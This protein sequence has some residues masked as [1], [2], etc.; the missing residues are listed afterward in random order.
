MHAAR[1]RARARSR[2]SGLRLS[3]FAFTPTACVCVVR[4]LLSLSYAARATRCVVLGSG[5]GFVPAALRQAQRDAGIGAESETV[6]VDGDANPPGAPQPNYH[7]GGAA[8]SGGFRAAWPEVELV[9]AL[10]DDA[11]ELLRARWGA[12]DAIDVLVIDADHTHAQSLRDAELW[13]PLLRARG[14]VA[15]LHDTGGC[16]MGCAKTPGVLRARGYDVVNLPSFGD[17]IALVRAPRAP[18]SPAVLDLVGAPRY[19]A[20]D[21]EEWY[22]EIDDDADAAAARPAALERLCRYSSWHHWRELDANRSVDA[23]GAAEPPPFADA[24]G[25]LPVRERCIATLRALLRAS[26]TVAP[27]SPPRS[28]PSLP[29]PPP[30]RATG[31]ARGDADA[32]AAAAVALLATREISVEIIEPARDDAAGRGDAM[33]VQWSLYVRAGV[34]RHHLEALEACVAL[35]RAPGAGGGGGG[36]GD[37]AGG[38]G[39]TGSS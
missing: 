39:D 8:R 10:T 18:P 12:A 31:A 33:L 27:P 28:P 38:G 35:G 37:G 1:A 20:D 13:L 5:G 29:P 3:R 32:A 4:V 2:G 23:G 9:R 16:A 6:L 19:L 36:G 25:A 17:G 15:V 34:G 14:G 24:R 7:A 21:R 11:V 22:V 26:A 30:P